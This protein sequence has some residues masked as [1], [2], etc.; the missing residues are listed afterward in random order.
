MCANPAPMSTP[1]VALNPKNLLGEGAI[2]AR[3]NQ[4]AASKITTLTIKGAR[5]ARDCLTL[6]L[7][8]VKPQGV[9]ESQWSR[10][11]EKESKIRQTH[12]SVPLLPIT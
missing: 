10:K 12:I 8:T 6:S 4:A 11:N 5:G 1:T 7:F 9:L 2:I 3:N